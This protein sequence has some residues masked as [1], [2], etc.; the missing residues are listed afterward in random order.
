MP[1][2]RNAKIT[3]LRPS[4]GS[5]DVRIAQPTPKTADE[6][7]GTA[8]HRAWRDE[9]LRRAGYKCQGP[10]C[11]R[12]GCLLYADHIKEIKDGGVPFD[13]LNGQALCASCH[14]NKT[15]KEREK[16]LRPANARK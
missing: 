7:Y 10:G 1:K 14:T 3:L 11:R 8:S 9:V 12:T 5:M 6:I 4:V 16:R 13:P 2:P 15:V